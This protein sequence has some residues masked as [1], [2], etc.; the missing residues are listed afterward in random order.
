M[1]QMDV[2]RLKRA[3]GDS[4]SFRL[5]EEIPPLDHQGE[6]ISFAG[7]VKASLTVANNGKMLRVEGTVSGE[8]R[9]TCGRCL[10]PFSF[11][12]DLPLEE[13]YVNTDEGATEDTVA[14]TGDLLDV[15]PEVYKNIIMALPMKALC[16]EDCPGLC[17]GCGRRLDRGTCDCAGEEIDPRLSA[18]KKLLN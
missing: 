3:P 7:P 16:G 12:F 1:L 9:L 8:L 13:S 17:P 5:S 4:A 2:N 14:F 18:L 6:K 15:T 11:P 10:E